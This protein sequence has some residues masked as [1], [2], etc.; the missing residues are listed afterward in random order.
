VTR[1]ARPRR[2]RW[3]ATAIVALLGYA[4][5]VVMAA[6][7][8]A[9][10][11]LASS[12]PQDGAVLQ[13]PPERISLSFTE[14]VD[15]ELTENSVV[16]ADGTDVATRAPTVGE[17][18][19]DV[20]VALDDAL[21]DGV[22]TVTWRTVSATDTH[23]TAN[24]F[25]FGIGVE[26]GRVPTTASG[27]ATTPEPS[28]L[29]VAGRTALYIGFTVLLG[30]GCAAFFA[31]E[32]RNVARPWLLG[33]GWVALAFGAV[34]T[35]LAERTAVGV[36]LGT[37]LG[38]QA[39]GAYVRLMVAAVVVGA[40][41]LVACVRP[42]RASVGV[43]A[44][45]T[46]AAVVIRVE[47]G[48]AGGSVLEVLAQTLHVVGAC[49]WIGGLVWLVVSIRG[50]ATG[51]TVKRF[52]NLAAIGLGVLA[53]TGILRA[54]N[55]LGYTWW[56]DPLENGYSTALTL[57]VLAFVPLV[58]L[59]ALNRYG[60][61]PRFEREGSRPLLRS[62]AGE[63][64]LALTVFGITGVMT[65]LPPEGSAQ[66]T[67]ARPETVQVSG[68]DFATTT[69][70]RLEIAPGTVG[71]NSFVADVVDYDT[72]RP[73]TGVRSVSLRF[74]FPDRPEAGSTLDLE[75]GAN[76]SW[77]AG[78]TN[79]SLFGT[80]EVT[81]LV[82][83]GESSV[84]VPMLVTPRPPDQD[85]AVS[86]QEGQPTLYTFSTADG[87]QLQAYV[88]PGE[89]GRTN[90]VH[91][92]AFDTEGD[93]LPL[94]SA[95]ITGAVPGGDILGSEPIRFGPGH[96]AANMDLTQGTWTF[97]LSARTRDGRTLQA[98]FEQRL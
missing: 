78:G 71:A 35:T 52:S 76:D 82:A 77:E 67:R 75:R 8:V 85:V 1:P 30:A 47:G 74:T 64:A 87:S 65:G 14:P 22:Y 63:L 91:L 69:T 96:F 95:T 15:L 98:V 11:N 73:L 70:V 2:D 93:E 5:L 57:K 92:T 54:S 9:H 90:Q 50:G 3:A 58:G 86:R 84:E 24:A 88:D 66:P 13:R 46:T 51:A 62:V 28:V 31:V 59:G 55:E 72:H 18:A 38:S 89:S 80:W 12:S 25:T 7:A 44:A 19:R 26:P 6:P 34:A 97:A 32:P 81:A 37:L 29:A 79:L 56:L 17:T 33:S 48:H 36:P 16:A 43:L 10:A 23:L 39:G 21:P 45:A 94:R 61:V 40:T 83:S 53:L 27:G 68:S 60:N 4:W 41:A 20:V 42:S 49:A